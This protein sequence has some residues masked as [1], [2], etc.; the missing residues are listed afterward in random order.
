MSPAA[1][2]WDITRL[3]AVSAEYL[4]GKGSTSPRLDAELLL[5]ETLGLQRIDLYTQYDRPLTEAE[6]A[7]FRELVSRRARQEPVAYILGRA[8]FRYLT[9]EV[10]PA[11]LIPRPETEELVQSVLDWLETH[12]LLPA[13]SET[14]AGGG[15]AA[16]PPRVVDVGTGSG[17]IALALASEAGLRVLATDVSDEALAVATRNR[18]ALGLEGLVELRAADLLAGVRSGSL[19]VVVANP[20]Y[21]TE[22]ELAGLDPGVRLFR[23]ESRPTGGGRRSRRLPAVDSAGLTSPGTR[24]RPF[25]GSGRDPGGP[26]RRPGAGGRLRAGRRHSGHVRQGAHSAGGE[27][28]R[29]APRKRGA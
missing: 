15:A 27:G 2:R 10:S 5:A 14:T 28:G 1:A 25:P 7:A 17:A 29:S 21:V 22:A 23:A 16:E 8:A 9:L 11:V 12:P 6:V 3:L 4:A 24:R 20:P 19:R 18:Q 13:D 26:G